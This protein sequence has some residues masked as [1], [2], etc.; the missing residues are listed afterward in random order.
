MKTSTE[1]TTEFYQAMF[2]NEGWE[3][4]LADTATYLGPISSLVEGK[5]AVVEVTKQFLQNKY[6]GKIKSMISQEDTVCVRTY[7]QIGHPDVAL[8]EVDACE[9]IKVKDEKVISWE[10]HFD[11]LKVSQ[12]GEKM[13]QMQAQD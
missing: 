13:K 1:I 9:I 11:S 12:F 8:L 7:Y 2:K 6:T 10:A 4:L 3:H 5:E